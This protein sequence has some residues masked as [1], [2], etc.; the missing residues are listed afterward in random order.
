MGNDVFDGMAESSEIFK[1]IDR[2][3]DGT[4]TL[5]ELRD[6]VFRSRKIKK[7]LHL[8]TS[9]DARSFFWEADVDESKSLTFEEFIAMCRF[10]NVVVSSVTKDKKATDDKIKEAFEG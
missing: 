9:N 10:K 1:R 5:K 6:A 2:N 8:K 4:V 7:A 3:G